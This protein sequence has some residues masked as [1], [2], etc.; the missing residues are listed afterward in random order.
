MASISAGTLI[1]DECELL[2][3]P[4]RAKV[5]ID[6]IRRHFEAMENSP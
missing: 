2:Q 6:I 3:R 4:K 1:S 5:L